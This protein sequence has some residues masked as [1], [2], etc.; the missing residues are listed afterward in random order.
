LQR[1][2]GLVLAKQL[3]NLLD[4]FCS[5]CLYNLAHG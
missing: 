4:L 3:P 1:Q 5:D 2:L